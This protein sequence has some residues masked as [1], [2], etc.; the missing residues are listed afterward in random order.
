MASENG[1]KIKVKYGY[2]FNREVNVFTDYVNDLYKTKAESDDNVHRNIS[3]SLLNNLLGRFGMSIN[4]PVTALLDNKTLEVIESTRKIMSTIP[5][6]PDSNL[7]TFD[8]VVSREKCLEFGVNYTEA[9]ERVMDVKAIDRGKEFTNVNIAIS[10]AVNS[11]ARIYMAKLKLDLISKGYT[12]YYTD[13]DSLV[14]DKPLD[15]SLIGLELGKFKLEYFIERGYFISSK[16]Y[17]ILTNKK[18]KYGNN[19]MKSIIKSKSGNSKY[20]TEGDFISLLYNN[21]V[22]AEKTTSKILY[23][24]G[25]VNINTIPL[26]YQ[27]NAYKNRS[28]IFDKGM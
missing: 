25:S 28:K 4:K 7:T 26:E 2:T 8:P 23:D 11:Y 12:L 16:M 9:L 24:R 5:L 3:K 15:N 13:T 21:N 17:C 18:D 1:Y 20:L 6:G 22:I 19:I 10:A 27:A 14:I